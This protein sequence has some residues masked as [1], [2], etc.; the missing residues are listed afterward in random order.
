MPDLICL[1]GRG[2]NDLFQITRIFEFGLFDLK[3]Q[4]KNSRFGTIEESWE[5]ET[6]VNGG[7]DSFMDCRK[8]LMVTTER[9]S[10][11]KSMMLLNIL[12]S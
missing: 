7:F 2:K 8:T 12:L 1:K 4:R 5:R 9:Q 10:R 3:W 11:E 6:Q